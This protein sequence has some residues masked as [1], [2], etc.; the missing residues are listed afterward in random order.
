MPYK[1]LKKLAE[2]LENFPDIF[3]L[4]DEIYSRIIFDNN[5]HVSLKSF[6]EIKDRVIVL[7]G[8]SKNF[9]NDWLETR[10]WNIP[11]ENF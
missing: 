6:S 9:C 11:K 7:D 4:S 2:G 1:E 10:L 5:K 8:W 3:I